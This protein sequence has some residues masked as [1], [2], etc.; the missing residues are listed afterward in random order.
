MFK[1]YANATTGIDDDYVPRSFSVSQNY[2]NPFNARTNIN[3]SIERESDVSIGVY[4]IGGQLVADLSGHYRP[5]DHV[6]TWDA[7]D[8]ASGVYFYRV[9]S[10]DNSQ[11]R[12]MVLL[13]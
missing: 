6:V 1:V 9:V 5:G 3:F 2:P 12:K 11:T 7:S 13:K 4:N 10:N 8:A